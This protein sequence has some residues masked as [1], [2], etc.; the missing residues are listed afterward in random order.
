MTTRSTDTC[1]KLGRV[2]SLGQHA[3]IIISLQY[4][5]VAQ[6]H[7]LTHR[8]GDVSNIRNE[9]EVDIATLNAVSHIVRPVMRNF[10]GGDTE[11]SD[12]DRFSFLYDSPVCGRN[13]LGHTIALLHPP[14]NHFCGIDRN[15]ELLAQVSHTTH[16]IGMVMGDKYAHDRL[17]GNSSFTQ[18]FAHHADAYTAI[19]EDA[20]RGHSQIKAVTTTSACQTYKFQIHQGFRYLFTSEDSTK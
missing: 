11:I 18:D 19:D 13:F 16:M 5:V 12:T 7:I 14:M 9:A 20:I 8:R 10:K 2:G 1:L 6:G 4:Q 3:L 17:Y 15:V